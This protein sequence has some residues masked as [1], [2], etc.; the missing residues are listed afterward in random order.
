[1][2]TYDP[3]VG[4]KLIIS[5]IIHG[6]DEQRSQIVNSIEKFSNRTIKRTDLLLRYP[7]TKSMVHQ[8][9]KEASNFAFIVL[10]KTKNGTVFGSYS[11]GIRKSTFIF[12]FISSLK[13]K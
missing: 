10:Y 9:P 5:V 2:Q 6:N 8:L 1:M 3:P 4:M 13:E 11:E 12:R 7:E